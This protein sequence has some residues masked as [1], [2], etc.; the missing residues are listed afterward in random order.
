MYINSIRF[1]YEAIGMEAELCVTILK[2][3]ILFLILNII[4]VNISKKLL[5]SLLNGY[6]FPNLFKL[7]NKN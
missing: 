6:T 3:Y 4:F 2:Y 7:L 1:L 5:L